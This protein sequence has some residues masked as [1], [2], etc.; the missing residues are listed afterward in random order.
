M[1]RPK[2]AGVVVENL[3]EMRGAEGALARTGFWPVPARAQRLSS[4]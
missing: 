3:E 1:P 4:G 2:I